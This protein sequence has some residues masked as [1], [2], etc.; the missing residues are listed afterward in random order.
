MIDSVR[1][2]Q[3]D[4][5]TFSILIPTW[6]SLPYLRLCVD[7]IRKNSKH[8]HQIIVHINEGRDGT[9][10]WVEKS[11][12]SYTYSKQNIGVC[13]AL[14]AMRRLVETDYILYMNDDMYVCPDWDEPLLQEIQGLPDNRFFL[15]ST[16]LQPRKFRCSSVISPAP[17]GESVKSFDEPGLLA[18]YREFQHEDWAGSTWPPNVVH[19]DIWDLVGGYSVEFSPGMY[20]DPDFTAKLVLAGVRYFKGI[21][22]SRVYHFEARSTSRVK[23]NAGSKQ[24][25]MKWG[26]TSSSF[27]RKVVRRG[28]PFSAVAGEAQPKLGASLLRARLKRAFLAF[29]ETGSAR[30]V[31]EL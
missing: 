14:N 18:R 15:S 12:L 5:A 16:L 27:M 13:W 26:I 6:N 29:S 28:A 7:S 20:S 23:K 25:L 21:S 22:R 4:G 31:W 10:E 2:A 1:R 19:R 24:F 11:G 8:R 3:V 9:L 30:K 17:F